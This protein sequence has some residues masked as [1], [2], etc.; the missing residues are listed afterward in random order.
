MRKTSLVIAVLL[1]VGCVSQPEPPSGSNAGPGQSQTPIAPFTAGNKT[2]YEVFGEV[3]E[4]MPNSFG[5]LDIGVASW[6]GKKFH[7]RLTS[8]GETYDMYQLSAA[9]KTLP[10]PTMVKVTN[11]D[12]GQHVILRINDRGP[13]HDNRLIDLSFAAAKALGY[14]DQGIAPVVVEALDELNHPQRYAKLHPQQSPRQNPQVTDSPETKYY[15][16]LGAFSELRW[17]NQLKE[18]VGNLF[19]KEGRNVGLRILQSER[20]ELVLHKVWLGPIKNEDQ[21]ELIASLVESAN[22][23]KPI[24]VEVD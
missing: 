23:G 17:A 8:N 1:L 11:L 5:Y 19:A 12:N 24:N 16:Q 6:Y 18:Q 22:L 7:G 15:L 3:Y 10:I 4:L 20:D 21:R 13:F 9:H 14:S 2:P